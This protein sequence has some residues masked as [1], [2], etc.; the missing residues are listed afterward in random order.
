[1]AGRGDAASAAEEAARTSY[2]RLV[3]YL[4]S[5]TRDVAAAE[6]ALAEAFRAALEAWPRTGVPAKPEAWLLASARNR[7]VDMARHDVVRNRVADTLR[8]VAEEAAEHAATQTTFP[9]ERLKLLFICAHP[10][11]DAGARTPLMLQTVLG[12]D[13]ARIASAFLVAPK[14]MAQRLVRAKAKIRDAGI[15][16]QMPEADQLEDR[17]GAVLDAIYAAYGTG[18]EDAVGIDPRRRGLA[19]EAIWLAR[20]VVRLLPALAEAK[21]LLA[22]MLYCEARR[23][24]RRTAEGDYVPLSEQDVSLWSLPM[25]DEAERVLSEAASMRRLGRYQLEAA[26]QSAH[27]QRAMT[28]CTDWAAIALLYESLIATAPTIGGLIGRAAALAEHR[29]PEAGV[30]ALDAIDGD[31]V[32]SHQPYWAVRGDLLA[33]VGRNADAMAAY[34]RAIGLTEDRSVRSFLQKKRADLGPA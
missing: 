2:S 19:D 1:M 21:G 14:T 13:A 7:I 18:W 33:R 4:A 20:L 3:A 32:T 22:L 30:H 17:A 12:L 26:I 31:L 9:D 5:R 6:D 29:G 27:G 25:I 15:A 16:F 34:T 24:A 23:P 10:A 8:L 11:I 28:G